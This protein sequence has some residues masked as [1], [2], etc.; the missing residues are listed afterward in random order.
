MVGVGVSCGAA[1]PWRPAGGWS[2]LPI[3]EDYY[4]TDLTGDGATQEGWAG[5]KL[6]APA[7]MSTSAQRPTFRASLFGEPAVEFAAQSVP[8]TDTAKRFTI[9]ALTALP[10]EYAVR[11]RFPTGDQSTASTYFGAPLAYNWTQANSFGGYFLQ[12]GD[13]NRSRFYAYGRAWMSRGAEQ[14]TDLDTRLYGGFTGLTGWCG[15][16]N[17]TA[18]LDQW[19]CLRVRPANAGQS[20]AAL[21]MNGVYGTSLVM[22]R[23]V[24]FSRQ[25]TA[26]EAALVDA[27]LGA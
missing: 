1:Q 16:Y 20:I 26:G 18:G 8:G 2:A 25:L 15:T 21:W 4:A 12:G 6:A 17:G 27:T 7:A 3:V 10:P 5:R 13:S 19:F 24:I 11:M 22:S 14:G 9:A 23:V